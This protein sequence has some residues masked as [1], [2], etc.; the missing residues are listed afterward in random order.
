DLD[1]N[2]FYSPGEG[3]SGVTIDASGPVHLSTT[4]FSSGGYSLQLPSGTY[5][6]TVSGVGFGPSQT[7]SLAVGAINTKQDFQ[8]AVATAP[9]DQLAVWS[10]DWKLD[11]NAN[12]IWDDSG[13]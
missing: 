13:G 1:H 4:T 3:I 12:Q 9:V 8:P 2:S 7:V 10:G 11:T 6:V 5:S